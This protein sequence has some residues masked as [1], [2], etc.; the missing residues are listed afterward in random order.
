MRLIQTLKLFLKFQSPF[1][2]VILEYG[3]PVENTVHIYAAVKYAMRS[4]L[5][6]LTVVSKENPLVEGVGKEDE[7]RG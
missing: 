5:T 4:P 3:V 7:N 6:V 1:K 2:D